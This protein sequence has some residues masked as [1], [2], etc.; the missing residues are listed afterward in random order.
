MESTKPDGEIIEPSISPEIDVS[1]DEI[2]KVKQGH[3]LAELLETERAYVSELS[4]IL[5]VRF[6]NN[7]K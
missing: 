3:I 5:T 7:N 4:S 2:H 1:Q 6:Y